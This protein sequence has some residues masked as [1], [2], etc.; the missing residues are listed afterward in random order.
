MSYTAADLNAMT[1]K[2]GLLPLAKSLGMRGYSKLRK[3]DLVAAIIAHTAPVKILDVEV[4]A[5]HT[6]IVKIM[7]QVA[8]VTFSATPVK[9]VESAPKAATVATLTKST[10]PHAQDST[11]DLIEAFRYM[12]AERHLARGLRHAKLT[13]KLAGIKAELKARK[14]NTREV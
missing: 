3:A 4:E 11:E 6:E 10:N 12:R 9:A 1:V 7:T 2:T 5:D 14:V 8:P 13:V